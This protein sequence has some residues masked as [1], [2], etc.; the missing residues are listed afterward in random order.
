MIY[1]F[2]GEL[3]YYIVLFEGFCLIWGI[4]II[5]IIIWVIIVCCDWWDKV[6]DEE[7]FDYDDRRYKVKV[8]SLIWF[9]LIMGKIRLFKWWKVFFIRMFYYFLV[10][11]DYIFIKII[12]DY[13]INGESMFCGNGLFE[14]FV[15][16]C[17]CD[18]EKSILD[19]VFKERL[20]KC[21]V[22]V[23]YWMFFEWGMVRELLIIVIYIVCKGDY[24]EVFII[25][26]GSI[27][28]NDL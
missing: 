22:I 2:D 24:E 10:K 5:D 18:D 8:K 25:E 11:V 4:C 1:D 7:W 20:N 23:C 19:D 28:C 26:L 13:Y 14:V 3:G 21:R 6:C 16:K 27:D 17:R 9:R 15:R 12:G